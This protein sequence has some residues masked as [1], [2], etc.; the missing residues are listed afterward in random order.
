VPWAIV[1]ANNRPETGVALK[2][3]RF[4]A[5]AAMLGTCSRP[6][7]CRLNRTAGLVSS[8][9]A[10]STAASCAGAEKLGEHRAGRHR[11]WL[12]VSM[13]ER[14]ALEIRLLMLSKL[15][16]AR[17]AAHAITSSAHCR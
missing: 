1:A 10:G 17:A 4:F 11:A 12:A 13:F 15:Q 2:P 7:Y 9:I 16:V 8:T 14:A 3:R 6:E 5:P